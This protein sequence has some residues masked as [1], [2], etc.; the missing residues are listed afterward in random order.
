MSDQVDHEKVSEL[1]QVNADLNRSLRRCRVLL[2]D[3][4]AKLA[5][6]SNDRTAFDNDDEGED[7]ESDSA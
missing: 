5:A 2:D 1:R 6:N 4:R 3:C 7:S